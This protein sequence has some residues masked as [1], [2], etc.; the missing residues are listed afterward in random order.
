MNETNCY[1]VLNQTPKP[2]MLSNSFYCF[3]KYNKGKIEE[4]KRIEMVQIFD[5]KTLSPTGK[6]TN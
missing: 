2:F 3:Q 6:Y 4:R 1:F 5:N